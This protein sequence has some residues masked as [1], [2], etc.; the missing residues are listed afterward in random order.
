MTLLA[1]IIIDCINRLPPTLMTVI[2]YV[3]HVIFIFLIYRASFALA[4]ASGIRRSKVEYWKNIK[5]S[6]GNE[7][8]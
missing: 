4:K 6:I 1:S 7:C 8:D 2:L 5:N 3:L